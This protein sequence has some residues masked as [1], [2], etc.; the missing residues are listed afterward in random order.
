MSH[1][2]VGT[3]TINSN[4]TPIRKYDDGL[5]GVEVEGSTIYAGKS[6]EEIIEKLEADKIK[7]T[8]V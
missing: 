2:V 6:L 8:I 4:I 1:E 5:F 7:Y 3:A